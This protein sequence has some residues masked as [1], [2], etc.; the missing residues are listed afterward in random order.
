MS[1]S[2]SLLFHV[3]CSARGGNC[4]AAPPPY[5]LIIANLLLIHIN[6]Q[7]ISDLSLAIVSTRHFFYHIFGLDFGLSFLIF[8]SQV[9]ATETVRPQTDDIYRILKP[10]LRMLC[11]RGL[12]SMDN[13]VFRLHYNQATV[14]RTIPQA[15]VSRNSLFGYSHRKPMH[16]KHVQL[17]CVMS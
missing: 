13:N 14:M 17:S 9:S 5:C 1:D 7:L 12:Q 2:H 8:Y 10:L 15:V 6:Q 16:H 4:A 3:I 11:Y